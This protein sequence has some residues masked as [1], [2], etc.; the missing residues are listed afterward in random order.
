MEPINSPRSIIK[1]HSAQPATHQ[2]TQQTTLA[3]GPVYDQAVQNLVEM[4]FE[5]ENVKS[6]M[7]A[8][9][10]NPG[11]FILIKRSCC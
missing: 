4:G 2:P 3:T 5:L 9:F 7:K 1:P 8:A 10:N 11:L 6:A